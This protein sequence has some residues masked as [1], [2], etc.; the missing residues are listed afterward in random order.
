MRTLSTILAFLTPAVAF[1]HEAP[2]SH[3]HPHGDW[4]LTALALLAAGAL[5]AVIVPAWK[6]RRE[7]DRK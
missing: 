3:A 1:A 6:A 5:A 7:R 4:T 2:A